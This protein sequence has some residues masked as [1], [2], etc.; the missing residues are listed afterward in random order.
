MIN[1]STVDGYSGSDSFAVSF[2]RILSHLSATSLT[3]SWSEKR[4]HTVRW[5]HVLHDTS[6]S[7]ALRYSGLKTRVVCVLSVYV[8]CARVWVTPDVRGIDGRRPV[9]LLAG[10]V[11]ED[12]EAADVGVLV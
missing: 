3:R 8:H 2:S 12:A 11:R 9:S 1:D 4:M 10:A 7:A 6:I 5:L